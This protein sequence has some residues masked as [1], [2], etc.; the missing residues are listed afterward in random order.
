MDKGLRLAR[1]ARPVLTDG[2]ARRA[3]PTEKRMTSTRRPK[4]DARERKQATDEK[5]V[6]ARRKARRRVFRNI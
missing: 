5:Y 3:W 4:Q 1:V 6:V 2:W